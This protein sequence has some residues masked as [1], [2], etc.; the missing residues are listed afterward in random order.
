MRLR[1]I[2]AERYGALAG[3]TLGELGDGLT[4]VHGPNE[5]GKSS[6]TALVRHVLY[7]YPT[8][9]DSEAGYAVG[10]EGRCARLVFEDDSGAWV[11]ERTEG[12]HGGRVSVRTLAGPDRPELLDELTRGVSELAYR[13][14]FGFGLGEMAAIEDLRS[15][16]DS[17]ISRLYAASAG[18]RVSPQEV[19][20]A[21][22]R[23]AADLFKAAGRKPPV[24]ALIAELRSSR[25]ELRGLRT[26]A[27]SF[28]ADQEHL[29]EL[30]AQLDEARGVRDAARERATG[31]AVAVERAD[32]KLGIIDAQEEVLKTLRRERRQLEE[33]ASGIT[34]DE[35]LLAVAPELDALL[36]EAAGHTRATQSLGELEGALVRAET[37]AADAA[38]RTGL[39][40]E[41]LAGLGDGHDCTAAIEEAREDL[42]RLHGLADSRSEAVQRTAEIRAAAQGALARAVG[43][44][45]ISGDADEVIAERL[46]AVDALE[47]VRGGAHVTGRPRADIPVLIMLLSGLVAL[48]TGVFLREWVT[49][50][51]G[52]VL[53]VLGVVFLLGGRRGVLHAP[54]GD[55]H[56]YLTM[57]GLS[58]EAG[59]LE[60][61]RARRALEAARSAAEAAA[62]AEREAR[63]AEREASLAFDSLETRQTLWSAW[64]AER[65]L[66]ALL[67]PAA[68]ATLVA[69]VR[70]AHVGGVA[71]EDARQAYGHAAEQLDAFA[72]RFADAARPFT[73]APAVLSRD[74]VPALANRLRDALTAARAAVARRDEVS[75]AMTALDERIADEGDRAAKASGELLEVLARFDLAEGGTH[76]DL[77]LLCAG[78]EREQAEANAAYD[79]LAQTKHQLEGRLESGARERRIGELHLTEAGLAERLED[80]VDRHLV[81]AVASR[82]LTEAQDRYQR[83][84]Q[85]E[86]VR[87]ASRHFTTMTDGRYTGLAVPLGDGRIEVFDA[88][89]NTRTSELLSRGTAEQLY[90]AVRLGLIGQLGEVGAGLPVL[91]DD[92]LVNFDP[93]RRRGAAEAI[94]ELASGRQV[95]FFTC[96]PET[97]DMMAEVA[98]APVRLDLPRLGC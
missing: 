94:A 9:R 25:A 56:V 76:E 4:I 10:G 59:V 39:S 89:A 68:A 14:V 70:D 50:G 31:L 61:S 86:V 21:V 18:L 81:L 34:V 79:E 11:I 93:A 52:A 98:D 88:R 49:V 12:T 45:G 26:E 19:R 51:V 95:V 43:P 7:R 65:G 66:D 32:E 90:L 33:E 15:E 87:S 2:E 30:A 55:E 80:A 58:A 85:P 22:D 84:R 38:A 91:M 1:R 28:M 73:E 72:V 44:L 5:A 78:A 41:T 24:N 69:L 27:E 96:H 60:V 29:A 71:A 92:V 16:G 42:Q 77:R 74:D 8:G 3:A 20:A 64:L 97:A 57:L 17:V 13:T 63:E 53:A 75:R 37:R 46:A 48:G 62:A 83:E 35:A 40:A 36:E 47:V 82:L 54:A 6:F 23:E 67:S